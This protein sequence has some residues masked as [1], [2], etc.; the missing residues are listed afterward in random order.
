MNE[1]HAVRSYNV[2][3][4]RLHIERKNILFNSQTIN[5]NHYQ[6]QS[7]CTIAHVQQNDD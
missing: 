6:V 4:L 3:A 5:G 1:L 2:P 7:N